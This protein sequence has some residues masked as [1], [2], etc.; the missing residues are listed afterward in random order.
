M[1]A[2]PVLR[3]TRLVVAKL[4]Q[5]HRYTY[6]AAA[7]R[8]GSIMNFWSVQNGAHP[9]RQSVP[10]RLPVGQARDGHGLVFQV[11]T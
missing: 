9:P 11:E 8:N 7:R 1:A 10:Q 2:I 4:R 5:P 6:T 3:A